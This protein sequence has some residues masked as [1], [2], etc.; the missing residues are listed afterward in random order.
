MKIEIARNN[1]TQFLDGVNIIVENDGTTMRYDVDKRELA[2]FANMLLDIAYDLLKKQ[3]DTKYDE[4][5]DKIADAMEII[6]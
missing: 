6:G 3:G 1:F 5:K 4:A 2:S